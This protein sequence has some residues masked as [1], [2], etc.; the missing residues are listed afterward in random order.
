MRHKYVQLFL[1]LFLIL[2][3][4]QAGILDHVD[5][6]LLLCHQVGP[7]DWLQQVAVGVFRWG[8]TRTYQ[9]II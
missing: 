6:Q 8:T 2:V 5:L 7:R 1:S 9:W 4:V 3:T